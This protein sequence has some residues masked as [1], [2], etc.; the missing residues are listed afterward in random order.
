MFYSAQTNGFY[1][2]EIH[3]D[4]IP[5]DAVEITESEYDDL[6]AG[7]AQ[8][9]RITADAQGKPVLTDRGTQPTT[10]EQIATLRLAAYEAEADP[11]FFKSQRGEATQADWLAKVAEIKARFP[12]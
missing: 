12:E 9:H 6:L 3:G 11:L 10:P 2:A 1:N 4:A 5:S 8:G 7:Q